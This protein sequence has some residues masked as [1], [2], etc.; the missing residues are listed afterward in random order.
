MRSVEDLVVKNVGRVET[1]RPWMGGTTVQVVTVKVMAEP[2]MTAG[3]KGFPRPERT[4][5][6]AR[7]KA[8]TKFHP[9]VMTQPMTGAKVA[10]SPRPPGEG[11]WS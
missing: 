8:E 11:S 6:E 4:M 3:M 5:A 9:A 7:A 10:A 2:E 1:E